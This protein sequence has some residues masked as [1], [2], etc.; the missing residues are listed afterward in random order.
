LLWLRKFKILQNQRKTV[1]SDFSRTKQGGV[2]NWSS[3]GWSG[4]RRWYLFFLSIFF[5]SNPI[6][7]TPLG[8]RPRFARKKSL[9]KGKIDL[10]DVEEESPEPQKINSYVEESLP[11]PQ[12]T[13]KRMRPRLHVDYKSMHSWNEKECSNWLKWVSIT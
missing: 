1:F 9:F 10:P 7:E 8:L 3:V 2:Q 6:P 13:N 5:F 4:G 12:K 11:K